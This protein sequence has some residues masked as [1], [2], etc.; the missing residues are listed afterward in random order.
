MTLPGVPETVP[1]ASKIT[2]SGSGIVDEPYSAVE[3]PRG[4]IRWIFTACEFVPPDPV[5]SRPANIDPSGA[6]Q[7]RIGSVTSA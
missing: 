2:A 7:M 1:V 3:S 5:A 6:K 4:A